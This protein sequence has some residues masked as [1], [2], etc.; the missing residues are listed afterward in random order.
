MTNKEHREKINSCAQALADA[1][2]EAIA[3]GM[4]VNVNFDVVSCLGDPDMVVSSVT[5]E[6]SV[7]RILFSDESAG[8]ESCGHW[9]VLVGCKLGVSVRG[10]KTDGDFKCKLWEEKDYERY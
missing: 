8:C 6:P 1:V 5:C 7:D 10:R 3:D 9:S 2:N 4:I